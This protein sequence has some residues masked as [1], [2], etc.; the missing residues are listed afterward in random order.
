MELNQF[1][2]TKMETSDLTAVSGQT[3][4]LRSAKRFSSYSFTPDF[5]CKDSYMSQII[6]PFSVPLVFK[7][8][9]GVL[10]PTQLTLGEWH[11]TP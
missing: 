10:E 7:G 1:T 4:N 11:V 3:C 8:L 6:R 5:K 2:Q 9:Q